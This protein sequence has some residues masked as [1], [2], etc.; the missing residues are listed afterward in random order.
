MQIHSFIFNWRGQFEKTKEKEKIL[1]AIPD[2][3]VTVINSDES[4][5]DEDWV[6]I[7]EQ[8]FFTDQFNTALKLFQGD[9]F[10]HVQGDAS[11][12]KWKELVDDAKKYFNKYEWGVYAPNVDYTWY[13]SSRTD[14][15]GLVVSDVNL[16]IVGCPDCTC[17]FIHKDIINDFKER[18]ID[19]TP[20]TMGWGWDIIMP[21]FSFIRKRPVFRDYNHTIDHPPGTNYN[22]DKAEEE[23]LQLYNNLPDDLKLL[24]SYIKGDRSKIV[25]YFE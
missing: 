9:I 25:S 13:D 14:I 7:G 23:M 19:M 3:K 17:W 6:H 12:D 1:S 22:K 10:W 18:K 2:V 11:Y 24:F 15:S 4:H 5:M 16:K 8:S 20:Y 21:A